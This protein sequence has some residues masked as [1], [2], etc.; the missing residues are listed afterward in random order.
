LDL[1][2][3]PFNLEAE[4]LLRYSTSDVKPGD[5]PNRLVLLYRPK[6]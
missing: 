1:R 5:P 3:P 4:E 6:G 2:L